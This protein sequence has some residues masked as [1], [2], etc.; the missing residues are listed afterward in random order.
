MMMVED[1]KQEGVGSASDRLPNRDSHRSGECDYRG[2]ASLAV[3]DLVSMC[4]VT[5]N[6]S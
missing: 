4:R 5:S 2:A 6:D 3:K 1:K